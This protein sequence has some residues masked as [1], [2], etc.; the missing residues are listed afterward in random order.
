VIIS[1]E[2]GVRKPTVRIFQT[3]A[4]RFKVELSEM[5][6]VG[7]ERDSDFAGAEA[8]GLQALLVDHET[9]KLA[10]ILSRLG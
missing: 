2:I 4:R 10:D 7:D 5:L 6:H 3:A 9:A 8:A 1:S